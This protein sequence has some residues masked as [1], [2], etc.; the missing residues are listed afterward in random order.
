MV[1]VPVPLFSTGGKDTYRQSQN[2]ALKATTTLSKDGKVIGSS[3]YPG[4]GSFTAPD[5]GVY[6]IRSQATRELPWTALGTSAEAVW[7]VPDKLVDG[8]LPLLVVR[9]SADQEARAGR[10]HC[11]KV[12]V[13]KPAGSR[14][15]KLGVEVSFDDGKT[16]R[17]CRS[18]R[19][20]R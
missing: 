16:W 7:T 4:W 20:T 13:Q 12:D 6:E 11:L 9:T 1:T 10:L 5:A 17:R 14:I 8:P 19:A 18:S 15:M 3:T 2:A